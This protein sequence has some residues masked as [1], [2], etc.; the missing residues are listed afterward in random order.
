MSHHATTRAWESGAKGNDMLVLLALADYAGGHDDPYD[1][2]YPAVPTIAKKTGIAPRTV[3]RCLRS[4]EDHGV[5]A[6]TGEHTW[7]PGKVTTQ[8]RLTGVVLGGRQSDTPDNDDRGGASPC[9][10]TLSSNPVLKEKKRADARERVDGEQRTV[11]DIFEY[12]KVRCRHLTAKPTRERLE[13]VKARLKEGYTVEQ[14]R[15][16]I[17][18][19]AC[20]A[21]VNDS[22]KR[23]DDLELI[24]RTGSKL[25]SFIDRAAPPLANG[26][27][28]HPIRPTNRSGKPSFAELM[29][30][31]DAANPRL[32]A[33]AAQ[34]QQHALQLTERT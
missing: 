14:I 23:F 6:R 27:N 22:G 10:P 5:I 28:V 3:Q 2:A 17:D 20:G 9:H 11:S 13:K 32:Q 8:Y 30:G 34:A 1:Y 21:F 16:A 31:L 24:C 15:S 29:S 18:G 26:G 25:E 19:A 4:L 12:W 7:R 33:Q